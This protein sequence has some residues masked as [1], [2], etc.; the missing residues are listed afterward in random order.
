MDEIKKVII[1]TVSDF[2]EFLKTN[3]EKKDYRMYRGEHS[4]T[5]TLLP[6]IGRLYKT[7]KRK[8][9]SAD[10]KKILDDFKSSAYPFIKNPDCSELELLAIA[11]H[12]KLPTRLLD[13]AHSPLVAAYFAVENPFTGNEEYS[14]IYIHKSETRADRCASFDPFTI[15]EVKRY[16]PKHLDSRII[17]QG[18]IF[19]V[20]NDPYTPW[21]SPDLEMALIHREIRAEIKRVLH[22]MGVNASTIYP[23]MDG[24]AKYAAW[25]FTDLH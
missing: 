20:H 11:Q 8:L 24:V 12:H 19:T 23:E 22:R 17:G 14:R 16:V 15:G 21:E 7:D 2:F 3:V 6:S 1:M 5:F 4:S 13:W 18:G 9:T 25:A 10:E